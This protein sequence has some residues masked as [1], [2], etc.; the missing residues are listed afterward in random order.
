MLAELLRVLEGPDWEFILSVEDGL[1]LGADEVMDRTPAVFEEKARRN[2]DEGLVPGAAEASKYMR[3]GE[4]ADNVEEPFAAV[5]RDGWMV[6]HTN[7]E[8]AEKVDE[9][10]H[11][12]AFAVIDEGDSARRIHVIHDSSKR[13]H[14]CQSS[15][16]VVR[17]ASIRWCGGTHRPSVGKA[18][19]GKAALGRSRGHREGPQADQAP[20]RRRIAATCPPGWTRITIG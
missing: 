8:A 3:L 16:P 13:A 11:V 20:V 5:A 1:K 9:R 4:D 6:A 14:A 15:D 12:V 19:G 18:S 17:P 2:L 7:A 10:L